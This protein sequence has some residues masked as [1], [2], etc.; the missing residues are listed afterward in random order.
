MSGLTGREIV[1]PAS[2]GNL[3]PGF[4]TIGLALALYLRLR[5]REV[6]DDGRGRL[7]CEFTE[8]R[9]RGANGIRRAFALGAL[10]RRA[11][12]LIVSVR[13]EIPQGAG[14]GSSAAATIAGLRL[15]AAVDGSR[16][17]QEILADAYKLERHPD[18]AAAALFGG[19]STS[20]VLPNGRVDVRLWRWPS[21]W[22]LVIA[23]PDTPLSTRRSRGVLPARVPLA[24]AAFNFQ[25][26]ARLLAAV[27]DKDSSALREAMADRCHQI[28][29][30]RLVPQLCDAI[31][32]RH[33][34]MLGVCLSGAGPSIA[35]V[36]ER[37]L[38][39]VSRALAAIYRRAGISCV[40]RTLIV[41]QGKR[42]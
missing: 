31:E 17:S 18:N 10:R 24:D 20:C 1:V 29:R 25:R 35:A 23:T 12:S 38:A 5:V 28:Y 19:L 15:R 6:I 22:R 32:L 16:D 14:L 36:A 42:S 13:S 3:G 2:I 7:L 11:P 41:H 26:L 37:N 27:R 40:I 9:P 39:G 34:D 8:G 33:P 4:D 21:R 30:Q